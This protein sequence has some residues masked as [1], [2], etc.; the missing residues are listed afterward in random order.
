MQGELKYPQVDESAGCTIAI[1][2]VNQ[3]ILCNLYDKDSFLKRTKPI[4]DSEVIE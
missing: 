2:Q 1:I 4:E 3:G